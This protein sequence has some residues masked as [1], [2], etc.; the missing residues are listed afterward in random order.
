MDKIYTDAFAEAYAEGRAKMSVYSVKC[1]MENLNL[2]L[3]EALNILEI[4]ID[5]YENA[6]KLIKE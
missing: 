1:V 4:T 6:M 3:Q 5:D 2:T